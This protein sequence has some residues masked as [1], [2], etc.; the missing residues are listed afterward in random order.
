MEE[1]DVFFNL[2]L[3]LCD[4]VSMLQALLDMTVEHDAHSGY[5]CQS[6]WNYAPAVAQSNKVLTQVKELLDRLDR[7][8]IKARARS[9]SNINNLH[10][11]PC[12]VGG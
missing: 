5:N 6:G 10:Y 8:S 9:E 11:P 7:E 2:M 4:D 12:V 1:I 3:A